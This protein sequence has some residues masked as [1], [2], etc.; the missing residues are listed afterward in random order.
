MD[1]TFIY[2][3]FTILSIWMCFYCYIKGAKVIGRLNYILIILGLY[4]S[5]DSF[6]YMPNWTL[7]V[8]III[9]ASIIFY[10]FKGVLE[11]KNKKRLP[12]KT[13]SKKSIRLQGVIFAVLYV[14]LLFLI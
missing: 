13:I 1:K 7:Y 4:L 3:Y 11:I 12:D 14:V 9:A 5:L 10:Y 6:V 8:G 2:M